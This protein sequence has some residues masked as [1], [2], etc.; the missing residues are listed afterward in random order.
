[1]GGLLHALG[2]LNESDNIARRGL[3]RGAVGDPAGDGR[4]GEGCERKREGEKSERADGSLDGW[5]ASRILHLVLIRTT[6][7]SRPEAALLAAVVESPLYFARLEEERR[8][9]SRANTGVSPLR[10]TMK[11]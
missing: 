9:Q 2:E 1:V 8:G 5:H 10:I 11:L 6:A 3:A 4:G 7:S